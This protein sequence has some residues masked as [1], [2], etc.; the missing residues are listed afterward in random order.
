VTAAPKPARKPRGPSVA[1]PA[2]SKLLAA[3]FAAQYLGVP[4]GTLRDLHFSG[5]LDVVKLGKSGKRWFFL[6]AD[7]DR[8]I[9]SHKTV[10][11][12]YLITRR[13]ATA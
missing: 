5:Q 6:R 4:Y 7:L 13:A 11:R 9:D 10:V 12:P 3:K 2:T 1:P 8:L